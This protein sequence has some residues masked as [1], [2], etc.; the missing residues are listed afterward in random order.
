MEDDNIYYKD[1]K[2]RTVVCAIIGYIIQYGTNVKN[3][4]IS[5]ITILITLIEIDSQ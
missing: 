2:R 1:L 5:N 3:P 4:H